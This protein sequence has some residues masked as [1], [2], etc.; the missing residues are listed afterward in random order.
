MYEKGTG[1]QKD[2]KKAMQLYQEAAQEGDYSAEYNIG[3]TFELGENGEQSYKKAFEHYLIAAEHGNGCA[4]NDLGMFYAAG[5][6]VSADLALA[7]HWL[8]KA[9]VFRLN[10]DGFRTKHVV[11]ESL[12]I[13]AFVQYQL[14]HARHKTIPASLTK[15]SGLLEAQNLADYFQHECRD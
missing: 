5:T 8:Q 9:A 4:Q 11:E 7:T 1:V 6:G 2:M 3:Q 13:T 10:N 14:A 15:G 12:Y